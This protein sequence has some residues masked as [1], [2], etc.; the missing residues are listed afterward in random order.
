MATREAFIQELEGL[1]QEL[2]AMSQMVQDAIDS[3]F[4]ALTEHNEELAQKVI[5]GD[6]DVDNMERKI[7]THCL[8]LMLKQQPVASDLRH[9]STALKVVTDLE[10]MGDQA[11]DIADL[12]L[13]LEDADISLVSKHLPAMVANVKTMVKDAIHA[14][15]QRDPETAETFEQRDDLIDAFF[16]RV[17]REVIE[18]LKKD[19]DKSDVAVDLLMVAKYLERIADHAVNVLVLAKAL[20]GAG[21]LAL[22]Q[23]RLQVL[24]DL[25]VTEQLLVCLRSLAGAVETA[26]EVLDVRKDQLEVDGLDVTG[27]IDRAFNMHDVL[28]VEAA[29]NVYDC[30]DLADM[31]QELVAQTLALGRALDQTRDVDELNDGGGELLGV[32]LVAQPLEPRVRH[33]HDA[34]VRVDGAERIII[35][36]DARVR[37]SVEQRGLAH[38]R[39]PDDTKFHISL[40]ILKKSCIIKGFGVWRFRLYAIFTPIP[41]GLICRKPG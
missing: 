33:G 25:H 36:R 18:F 30:V 37:N 29:D 11:A 26:F 1:N 15:T 7:E 27:R 9:I 19:G 17:K 4:Q 13:R 32:M 5:K 8:T 20:E 16:E 10:R 38:I 21:G 12:S 31:G 40:H 3:S 28:V 39:Q 22:L 2:N 35:R 24:E 23:M 34:D 14:F 41:R 6:R